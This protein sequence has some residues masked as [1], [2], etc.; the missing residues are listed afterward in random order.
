MK[1]SEEFY[2]D[3]IVSMVSL[4]IKS[5]NTHEKHWISISNPLVT[6]MHTVTAHAEFMR[7]IADPMVI[8]WYRTWTYADQIERLGMGWDRSKGV[9]WS[10]YLPTHSLSQSIMYECQIYSVNSA[11]KTHF[12]SNGNKRVK[13]GLKLIQLHKCYC[14]CCSCCLLKV[15]GLWSCGWREFDKNWFG[16]AKESFSCDYRND[17]WNH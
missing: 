9:E 15:V 13:R 2:V 4:H 8:Q 3:S 7:K 12:N 1:I 11:R 6:H 14:C 5:I 16:L 10:G 17:K